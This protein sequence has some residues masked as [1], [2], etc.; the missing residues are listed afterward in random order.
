[1]KPCRLLHSTVYTA[2]RLKL[3]NFSIAPFDYSCSFVRRIPFGLIA[4]PG[5][6][7]KPQ[8]CLGVLFQRIH[9][10]HY[11]KRA[12]PISTDSYILP[13]KLRGYGK[14]SGQTFSSALKSPK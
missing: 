2:T 9:F 7:Q 3:P 12:C 1:M 4:V 8:A 10:R 14:N 6:E 11:Q 5:G 13:Q